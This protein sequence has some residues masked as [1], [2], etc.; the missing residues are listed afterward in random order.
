MSELRNLLYEKP[1]NSGVS[2][3][4]SAGKTYCST[5]CVKW[6]N[7]AAR[8]G[9]PKL[10]PDALAIGWSATHC[11]GENEVRTRGASSLSRTVKPVP[12]HRRGRSNLFHHAGRNRAT[13]ASSRR[14]S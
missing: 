1:A 3:V 2:T 5:W 11:P 13:A 8:N 12:G 7:N 9:R 10:P 4:K 6:K 14:V